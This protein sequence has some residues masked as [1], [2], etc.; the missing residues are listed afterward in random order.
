MS[1]FNALFGSTAMK[2]FPSGHKANAQAMQI[3]AVLSETNL[4]YSEF[5]KLQEGVMM[6]FKTFYTRFDQLAKKLKLRDK[7]LLKFKHYYEKLEKLKK[8]KA[9]KESIWNPAT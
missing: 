7:A 6:T 2:S 8:E 5:H 9:A 3:V 1:A 4:H